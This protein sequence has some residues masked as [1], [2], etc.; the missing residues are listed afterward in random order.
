VYSEAIFERGMEYFEEGRVGGVIKFKSKLIG[1]VRGTEKYRTE[2]DLSDLAS[3]C[4]CPYGTNCK[5]GVA[6][7]LQYFNR[8]YVDG[9]KIHLVPIIVP[10]SEKLIIFM[11]SCRSN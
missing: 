8:E 9:D 4:S 2:V 6:M 11:F 10:R 3:R 7:L 5:H 1:D